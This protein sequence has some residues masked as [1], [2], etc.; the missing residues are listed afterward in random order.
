MTT[1]IYKFA[2]KDGKIFNIYKYDLPGDSF[3][4]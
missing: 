3:S 2:Y 1:S 4:L